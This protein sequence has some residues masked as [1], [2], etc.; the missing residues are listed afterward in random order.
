MKSEFKIRERV[1][2]IKLLLN[3]YSQPNNALKDEMVALKW[4]LE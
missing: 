3:A 4:V 1:S 2:D